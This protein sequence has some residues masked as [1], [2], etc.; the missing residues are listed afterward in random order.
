MDAAYQAH[1]CHPQDNA[2]CGIEAV[3]RAVAAGTPMRIRRFRCL[4]EVLK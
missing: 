1:A 3:W 4:C 2:I